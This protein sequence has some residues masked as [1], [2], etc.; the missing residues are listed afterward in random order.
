MK[1]KRSCM[2]TNNFDQSFELLKNDIGYYLSRK[3]DF[4]F[5]TPKNLTLTL[6]YRC[7]QNCIMCSIRNNNMDKKYELSIEEAK[8][9]I[10]QMKQMRISELVLTGG[11]PVLLEDFF[12]ICNY[13][14]NNDIRV[15]AITNGY[16]PEYYVTKIISSKINH[17]QI[18]LDGAGAK[19]HDSIRG[20]KGGFDLTINN[21]NTLIKAGKSVGLT[22]TVMN[23]NFSE[24]L[25]IALLAKSLGATRLAVRPVHLDNTDP[26]NFKTDSNIWVPQDRLAEFEAVIDRLKEFNNKTG[27]ID[28]NP[29]LDWFKLYFKKGYIMPSNLC[30][31]GY[32]RLI[33]AFNEKDSYEVWMCGGMIGDIRKKSIRKIWY[34]KEARISRKKIRKCK[35][36]CL[37]PELYEP[38]LQNLRTIITSF[39]NNLKGKHEQ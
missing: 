28:F 33:I 5:C 34:S 17:I 19:T 36:A 25:D 6:T 29:D 11:E 38:G 13:A 9:I 30:Y 1:L 14:F 2:Q 7:N 3:L 26:R 23:Q 27:F 18:S 31:M 15:I 22:C 8:N 4:P 12:D 16:Y 39:K 21:I 24:L 35:K 32:N 20:V 10:D 37:F